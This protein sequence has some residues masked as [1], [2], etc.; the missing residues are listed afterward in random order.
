[1]IQAK[2]IIIMVL[3][4]VLLEILAAVIVTIK[5]SMMPDITNRSHEVIMLILNIKV[6]DH[7]SSCYIIKLYGLLVQIG[8]TICHIHT[9]HPIYIA[10]INSIVM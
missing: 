1:M 3:G 9:M 4:L 5:T 2:E 8:T 6:T 10:L 7:R